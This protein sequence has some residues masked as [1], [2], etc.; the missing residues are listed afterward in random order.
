VHDFVF[1]LR[2]A[3]T[4]VKQRKIRLSMAGKKTERPSLP[5]RKTIQSVFFLNKSRPS[6]AA[7][8]DKKRHFAEKH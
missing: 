7:L 5:T 2:G 8:C 4:A 3:P 6:K 1:Q